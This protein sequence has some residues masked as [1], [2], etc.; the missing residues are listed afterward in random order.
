MKKIFKLILAAFIFNQIQAPNELI[1]NETTQ[2][3]RQESNEASQTQELNES[4]QEQSS[5]EASQRNNNFIRDIIV[6]Q[7]EGGLFWSPPSFFDK[8]NKIQNHP[9][10][11]QSF[12]FSLSIDQSEE[13]YEEFFST[14]NK[15]N[16]KLFKL[17]AEIIL[18]IIKDFE[19]ELENAA[20]DTNFSFFR[21][22]LKQEK[23][24]SITV[25]TI[26]EFPP[27][28]QEEE[29]KTLKKRVLRIQNKI[30]NKLTPQQNNTSNNL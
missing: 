15:K 13:E 23:H 17:L 8:K 6:I 24:G 20:Q 18:K 21:L 19:E 3:Q 4:T 1:Q 5:N 22:L 7:K 9:I 14:N 26:Y 30:S 2:N 27:T 16:E 25:E 11:T 29:L 12:V 28:K 10:K